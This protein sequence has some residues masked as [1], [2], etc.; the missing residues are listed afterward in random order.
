MSRIRE[1]ERETVCGVGT[2]VGVLVPYSP[3]SQET[4]LHAR[5]VGNPADNCV[6]VLRS[7]FSY[8]TFGIIERRTISANTTCTNP[9]ADTRRGMKDTFG[10]AF[11]A[12]PFVTIKY[13]LLLSRIPEAYS[14]DLANPASPRHKF[15][16]VT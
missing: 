8:S 6:S 12:A 14:R 1:R 13:I 4:C 7:T 11:R 2:Y 3:M 16:R 5:R 9:V 10:G 15:R